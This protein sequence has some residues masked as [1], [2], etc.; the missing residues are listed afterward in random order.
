MVQ[1]NLNLVLNV[2]VS[3]LNCNLISITQL[4]DDNICK[5][6]LTKKL[7]VIQDLI[8]KRP[9]GVGEPKRVVHYFRKPTIEKVQANRLSPM[10]H[11]MPE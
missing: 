6:T 4:I 10:I 2:L 3:S 9:I 11:G 5:V 1:L 8:T 7:C